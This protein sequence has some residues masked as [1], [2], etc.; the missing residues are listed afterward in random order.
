MLLLFITALYCR[1]SIPDDL[2]CNFIKVQDGVQYFYWLATARTNPETAPLILWLTGGPGCSSSMACFAENGPY[3]IDED[4]TLLKHRY[5]WTEV[6]N[7]LYI[8]Q[9]VG[10][11]YSYSTYNFDPF[12]ISEKDVDELSFTFLQRFLDLRPEFRGRDFYISGESYG[13]HY[14]PSIA[15]H[16][17]M[18]ENELDLNLR[19]I[20]IGNGMVDPK[21]QFQYFVVYARKHA[22]G[23]PEQLAEMEASLPECMEE[24]DTCERTASFFDCNTAFSNCVSK[25]MGYLVNSTINPYDISKTHALNET[26]FQK[27][28]ERIQKF[29]DSPEVHKKCG[30]SQDAHWNGCDMKT[31]LGIVFGGDFLNSYAMNVEVV[32]ESR[33]NVLVYA[34]ELDFMCNW[35]GTEAWVNRHAGPV[36]SSAPYEPFDVPHGPGGLYK[37]AIHANT[38]LT[39]VKLFKAGHM[40]PHDQPESTLEMIKRFLVANITNVWNSDEYVVEYA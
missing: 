23:T 28:M 25:Q 6:A 36:W 8:D 39:L 1:A 40:A 2:Q 4:G 29:M 20:S 35:D 9:P 30:I 37:Q 31:Y 12:A 27:P 19:G 33:R 10:A 7:V 13:G 14:V 17:V 34:G 21:I 26:P 5:A 24:I 38:T 15:S 32:L 22:L 3:T 16:V 18:H 11:G